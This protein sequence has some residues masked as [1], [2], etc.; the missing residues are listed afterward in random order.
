MSCRRLLFI[1]LFCA[2][3]SAWAHKA[4]DSYL[5][6]D[7]RGS[8]VTAQWDIA[9]RDIDF[10]IGL[11]S[12]GNGEI[13]WGEL[14]TRQANV[15][16]WALSRLEVQRG[17]PCPLELTAL[18]VDT[19]TDGGYAVL[20]LAGV[21]PASAGDLQLGYRLL[22]DLDG[23]H[24][25]LLRL[26]VD[27]TTH[28]TVLSPTSG[29]LRFGPDAVSRLTQFRQYLVEGIW[30]IWIGFDHILFLLSLLLPAVLVHS[31]AGW[32][33]VA[34]FGEAWR[35]V[36]WVVTSFTAAHSITLSLAALGVLALPSRLVES[37]IAL[38]VV[39]AA[40]NNLYPVVAHR[41]WVV[42]FCFG[43]IHGFG[44]ASVLTELGL[45]AG[46]LVLSLVGFNLGVEV[47]QLAIVAGFLPLAFV[48]RHTAF[49]RRGVFVWG[50]LFTVLVAATWLVERAFDLKL[51]SR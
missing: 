12:D 39:L 41:R 6:I 19:H 34:R 2:H 13:T 43:L 5:V 7:A 47:G 20:R 29:T 48:L 18:Q 42:A 9:L 11:D 33:G 44:F 17:G 50:S 23:L 51:V 1:A 25:G 45:P 31:N 38:S 28:S 15:A 49:Y 26:T 21:C 27:G 3:F 8:E 37:A 10:A 36:L 35:E 4:S 24:R 40:A 14:R 46:A 32:R 22:F 30:H 16:A